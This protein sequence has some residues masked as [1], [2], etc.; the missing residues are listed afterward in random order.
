MDTKQEEDSDMSSL[1]IKEKSW[2]A[3]VKLVLTDILN[4]TKQLSLI[5]KNNF[6]VLRHYL[7]MIRL[8]I[9]VLSSINSV[10]SVGM[11]SFV[12]QSITSTSNCII[13]LIYGILGS[14]E[15][16]IGIQSKSD[17]EFETF[18][19]LKSLSIK[20]NWFNVLERSR[21]RIQHNI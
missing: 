6:L 19:A 13:S 17:K 7:F 2:S 3:D 10:L 12:S 8:P 5:H 16:F 18:Q 14:L 4:N 15:L 21:K 11:S 1:E 9:I 20:N